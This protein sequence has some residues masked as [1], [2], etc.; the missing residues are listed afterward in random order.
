MTQKERLLAALAGR[1][2]DRVP[3]WLREG[4]N[5]YREDRGAEEFACGWMNEPDYI[6]LWEFAREHCASIVGWS[7]GGHFNRLLG[8]PPSR[9][10]SR[11]ESLSPGV[12][13]TIV[14]IDTPKGPLQTVKERRRGENTGW[15]VKHAV[16]SMEDFEKLRRVP[17]QVDPPNFA[18]RERER[19]ALGDQGVMCLGLNS[20]WVAFSGCMP[21]EMAL[22][23]SVTNRETVHECLEEITRRTL[24]CLERVF[25]TPV[26]TIANLGGSEQC[27]PPMMSPAAFAEFVV[28]YDRRIVDFLNRRGVLVNCH[29]HGRVASALA[30]MVEAGY[31]STD[32]VEP[33][34]AGDVTMPQAREAAGDRLTL[35]GNLEFDELENADPER[36]R[37]RVREIMD[38]GRRRLVLSASAGPISRM[39]PRLIANYRALIEEAVESGQA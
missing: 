26:E 33:P 38:T 20:P 32:P 10:S 36:I 22:A 9:M 24:A 1:A 34:P 30:G 39:S 21:F 6:E 2:V 12:R 15:C 31:A 13:R 5:L 11:V 18:P 29:C 16:E 19:A 4:F 37:Q 23:W 8:I 17:F 7:P 35:L 3:I 14:T 27:T 28:P 25:E